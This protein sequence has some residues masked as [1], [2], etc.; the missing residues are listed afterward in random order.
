M[1]LYAVPYRVLFH[2]EICK[3][4]KRAEYACICDDAGHEE[5][6]K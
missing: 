3:E 1:Q 4:C 5:H 6:K 2:D